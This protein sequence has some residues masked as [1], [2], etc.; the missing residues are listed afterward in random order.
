MPVI[1]FGRSA[2]VEE[3]YGLP[4]V[5]LENWYVEEA[6]DRPDWGLRLIPTPGLVSFSTGGAK[7]RGCF[8]SDAVASGDVIACYATT[9]VRVNSAG[10]ETAISGTVTDDN[11]PVA[12]GASQVQLVVNTAGKVY[13]VTGSAVTEFTANITA[14]GA[15]GPI[16]DVAVVNNRHLYV[17]GNS[18]RVFYSATG[19][20]TTIKGFFTAERDPDF[21]SGILV[22][23]SNI[24]VMGQRKTEFWTATD[25]DLTPFIQRNGY[26]YEYGVIGPRARAQLGGSA[27]WVAHD[28][29]VM[30]WAGGIDRI[31]SHWIERMILSLALADRARV[32]VTAHSW[33]GHEFV[34]VTIPGKGT[35]VFDALTRAWHRR[36][37]LG[38]EL[39]TAWGFDYFVE[40]FGRVY[41]QELSTGKLVRLDAGASKEDGAT[42]RRVATA[43]V[44]VREPAR[45]RNLIIEGQA[46]VGAPGEAGELGD[47]HCMLRWS[48][49]GHV[50]EG[51]M[52]APIGMAGDYNY[53]TIF[54]ALG[55]FY[56][57]LAKVELAYSAPVAWT[58]YGASYNE[59]AY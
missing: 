33:T 50:F 45:V 32:R 39:A 55:T 49:N 31:S 37:D 27:Y 46:G 8:Q 53:R 51:E 12:W 57:P 25:S 47:P 54:G 40:A 34:S 36:R 58:V 19:D 11:E 48:L 35:Y 4:S 3:S 17:E 44:P 59:R 29:K 20:A 23:S 9:L 41:C 52:Q 38:D 1:P 13:T 10:A 16:I 18:G 7:G 15:S 5:A 6:P 30:R 56:P 2:Y 28:G 21:T 26:V 24:L 22:V 42:V 43:L 14:A